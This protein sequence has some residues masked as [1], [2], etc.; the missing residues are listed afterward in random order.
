MTIAPDRGPDR[1]PPPWR[2][3]G[4]PAIALGLLG[5]LCGVVGLWLGLSDG[6]SPASDPQ[7]SS[8]AVAE[9]VR[10]TVLVRV[11]SA[12]DPLPGAHTRI[13]GPDGTP[14]ENMTDAA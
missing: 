10:V 8:Q 4:K 12:T 14:S 6:G 9:P 2:R 1:P 13:V 11:R 5:I 7:A 3:W